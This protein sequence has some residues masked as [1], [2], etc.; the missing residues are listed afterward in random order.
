VLFRSQRVVAYFR[1]SRL[2]VVQVFS[3]VCVAHSVLD[4]VQCNRE[5]TLRSV[6]VA[7]V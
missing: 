4:R 2:N 1:P 7:C 5:A 6:S 3:E